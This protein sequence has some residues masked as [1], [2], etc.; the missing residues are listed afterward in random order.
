MTTDPILKKAT[1]EQL[2]PAVEE[3]V[4]AMFRS[5]TKVLNGDIEENPKLS[6]Y[7][8]AP[9]SP[10]FKGAYQT[11]L[12]PDE[13]D[14]AIRDTIDWFK[15]R[16]APFFFWWSGNDTQP[17][18]L[19]ERLESHGFEVFEKDAPAMV[20]DINQLNWDNPRPAELR[21]NQVADDS[22][23]LQWKQ[24]FIDA[25]GIP[26]FAGQAWVDATREV[27][28]GSTPWYLLLGTLRSEVVSCGLL[29]CGAGVAGLLG[30][31]TL[32]AYRRMGI[33]S[34]MQLERLRIARELGYQYAV[35][36]AS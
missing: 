26:E 20:A 19:G 15:L 34:A 11:R 24:A 17:K 33:G 35:L 21:L 1:D 3:N 30:L 6:R 16:N 8:A 4:F 7:H 5:M 13:T 25:F 10:I 29:Y 31:G 23:L 2:G 22:Q 28:I 27:G 9:S 14:M 18:D 32:P 12:T 36:F